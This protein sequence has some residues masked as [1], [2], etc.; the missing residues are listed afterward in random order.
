MTEEEIKTLTNKLEN[1][2]T[3][4]VTKMQDSQTTTMSKLFYTDKIERIR[5]E[6]K[7]M[8]KIDTNHASVTT[9]IDK[10]LVHAEKTN[11]RVT[12]LEKQVPGIIVRNRKEL[13]GAMVLSAFIFI[14]ESRDYIISILF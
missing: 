11:G 3:A 7:M 13:A 8:A 2:I 1:T 10:I 4:H 9:T 12:K 14:K 6:E 5:S